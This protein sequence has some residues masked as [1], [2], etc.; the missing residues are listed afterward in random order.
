MVAVARTFHVILIKP[1][2]YDD[3]GYPIQWLHSLIPANSLA[4][5]YGLTED[6]AAREVLG[7]NVSFRITAVDETTTRVVPSRLIKQIQS[8]G[9]MGIVCLVG[10]QTNQFPRAVDIARPFIAEKIPVCLGGFHVSGCMSMLKEMP[11]EMREAQNLGISFFLGEAEDRRLDAVFRDAYA[12]AL[13]PIYDQLSDLPGMANAPLPFLPASVL[14][15]SFPRVGSF[16]LG[17][18]CPFQCSFCAIINVHGRTSRYRTAEDVQA[19]IR[20]Y[21]EAGITHFMITDDN[22]ARNRNWEEMLDQLIY[23]REVEG[24]D[25]RLG[26]QVDTLCHKIPNFIEKCA[27]AGTVIAFVG[28][29]NINPANLAAA[30]KNQNRISEY[31]E[32]FQEWKKHRVFVTCGYIVGFPYDT[33]E[34]VLRDIEIIKS[35]L[36]IDSIY[37]TYLTPLPGSEDHKR[38]SEAGEYLD[39]DMNNYDLN[40]RVSHHPV[41]SDAEWDES[42]KVAYET[43]YTRDHMIT[44][45][46]RVYGVGSN[47]RITTQRLLSLQYFF[48]HGKL[49]Q[50]KSQGGVVPLRYRKDRRPGMPLETPLRFYLRYFGDLWRATAGFAATWAWFRY[51]LWKIHNDPMRAEYHDASMA[52]RSNA[53]PQ[54]LKL[55]T[56][57]TGAKENLAHEQKKHDIIARAKERAAAAAS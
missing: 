19:I 53:A 30:K 52:P 43:Y 28:L 47:R 1:A 36:L 8:D 13:E 2:P 56:E 49:R 29:E 38:A 50:Y 44:L 41:M 3:D 57:T 27:R 6:C 16:D 39:P 55:L 11:A 14:R 42:V 54:E 10:V 46:K 51:Q 4:C 18:G 34:T 32:M 12:G 40:H 17:R 9:G 35:E 45:M 31:R 21:C 37:F 5:L 25:L 7:E 23:L 33:K 22:L 20:R 26:I 48:V 15:K 24:L